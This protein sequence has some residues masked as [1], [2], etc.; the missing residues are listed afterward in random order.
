MAFEKKV[1]DNITCPRCNAVA[2]L[3]IDIKEPS[4]K[5][6]FVY[7][8]CKV[9]RL[10]RF[11]STTTKKAMKYDKII[12]KMIVEMNKYPEKSPARYALLAKINNMKLLKSRAEIGV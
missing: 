1:L 9:C 4:G 12:K 10:V 7:I 8:S 5:M 3:R 6:I 2:E 11:H